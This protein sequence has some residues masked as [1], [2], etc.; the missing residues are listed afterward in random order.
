[1]FFSNCGHSIKSSSK[2]FILYHHHFLW[3]VNRVHSFLHIPY[4]C[5][6]YSFF[7]PPFYLTPRL[8]QFLFQLCPNKAVR[9]NKR[10]SNELYWS[11][12]E[13]H[14]HHDQHCLYLTQIQIFRELILTRVL[15]RFDQDSSVTRSVVFNF[16]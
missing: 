9:L 13:N 1:M 4:Q 11:N 2:F 12:N 10:T 3:S 14:L 7:P 5:L 16:A 15:A 6:P 8:I